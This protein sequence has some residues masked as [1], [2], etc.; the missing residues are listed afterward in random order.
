MTWLIPPTSTSSGYHTR[1]HKINSGR[2][3]DYSDAGFAVHSTTGPSHSERRLPVGLDLSSHGR[4]ETP[5]SAIAV[6]KA[7][8]SGIVDLGGAG[9]GKVLDV[10]GNSNLIAV[11]SVIPT[12]QGKVGKGETWLAS[13]VYAVPAN[14]GGVGTGGGWEEEWKECEKG[15]QGIEGVKKLYPFVK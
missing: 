6:S 12:I 3:L 2:D 10:D 9:K 1:I 8:V 15:V 11:R 13:R 14:A 5:Q 4:Y 7:G